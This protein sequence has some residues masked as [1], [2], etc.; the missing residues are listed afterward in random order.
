MEN[1]VPI[2]SMYPPHNPEIKENQIQ[3]RRAKQ[4]EREK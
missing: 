3:I 1:E 2:R 4:N